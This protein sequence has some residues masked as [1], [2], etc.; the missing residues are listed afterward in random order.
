MT[1]STHP[2]P[3]V[4]PT[5]YMIRAHAPSSLTLEKCCNLVTPLLPQTLFMGTLTLLFLL[6]LCAMVLSSQVPQNYIVGLRDSHSLEDHLASLGN[7]I[8]VEQ[9]IPQITG[10][11]IPVSETNNDVLS[12]I[13][14]DSR[15]GFVVEKPRAFFFQNG[16]LGLET[17]D[18]TDYLEQR[19]WLT[20]QDQDPEVPV[21]D[22]NS[23]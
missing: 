14:R 17:D 9:R 19:M 6:G 16:H 7:D 18:L 8:D 13:R 15:V 1:S 22:D 12:R 10:Y 21:T 20:L 23:A 5:W 3:W 11:A 4:N 2:R